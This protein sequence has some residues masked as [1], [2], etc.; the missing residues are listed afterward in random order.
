MRFNDL[1]ATVLAGRGENDSSRAIMWRQCMDLLAQFDSDDAVGG[2]SHSADLDR[3]E[4]ALETLRRQVGTDQKLAALAELGS[5]LTSPRLVRFLMEEETPVQMAAMRRAR[6][7]DAQWP[8]IIAGAG[9]VGRAI[10]RRRDDLGLTARRA[11]EAYGPT[12]LSL[13]HVAG[14]SA[15]VVQ[16]VISAPG[17]N[18]D[19]NQIR[20]IVDRI[21]RFT[22][23]RQE[24][25]NRE[26]AGQGADTA[27]KPVERFA[28]FT[29][30]DG[31]VRSAYG[32]P[33]AALIGLRLATASPDHSTG[34]DGQIL[35][36]F[37]RRGAFR[38]GRLTIGAGPLAGC[39]LVD[40]DPMFD[41]RSGRFTGY[42]ANARRASERE[43]APVVANDV[44]PPTSASTS[45]RQLIHELRT[46]LSGVMGFAELIETQLLGPVSERY[47]GMA[48]DIVADVRGLVDILDDLDLAN[49]DVVSGG[50]A[51][52]GMGA[53]AAA[54]LG[55]AIERFGH[56][57]DGHRRVEAQAEA[58]LPAIAV[59]PV[60]AERMIMHFVRALAGCVGEESLVA[61][62]GRDGDA[63]ALAIDRP[64]AMAGLSEAQ[65]FDSGFEH[66]AVNMDAPVLGTGF[67]LRL[68]RR[69]AQ[70]NGGALTV[71]SDRFTLRLPVG[72]VANGEHGVGS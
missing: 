33:R 20:R 72:V 7:S 12:D 21:E 22:S 56:A 61:R 54:L 16:A 35:G 34:P 29:D 59:T 47:R 46:P 42:R 65:L 51:R 11:L 66:V 70:G 55:Q 36:A 27:S 26:A 45:L 52:E 8:G 9:P 5:R 23:E 37:R 15:P 48:R 57:T 10:L 30:S 25:G 39:W 19:S 3:A 17:A 44:E 28:L 14:A 18:D 13:S 41:Q 64:V 60:L 4:A 2:A 43:L 38:D 58:D 31:V 50:G 71:E 24:R 32:A 62:A 6:L 40:G 1:I 49:R 69:L 68:V 53:D 63:L 67:A